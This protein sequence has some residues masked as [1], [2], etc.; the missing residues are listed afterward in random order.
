MN[1]TY[2]KSKEQ[3]KETSKIISIDCIINNIQDKYENFYNNLGKLC[4]NILL[5]KDYDNELDEIIDNLKKYKELTGINI[6]FVELLKDMINRI[7]RKSFYKSS[8]FRNNMINKLLQ[9]VY[10]GINQC[11]AERIDKDVKEKAIT[12]FRNGVLKNLLGSNDES[13]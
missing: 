9:G 12:T 10:D 7:I 11:V 13:T 1:R 4:K 8:A 5:N 2:T 6:D 3:N